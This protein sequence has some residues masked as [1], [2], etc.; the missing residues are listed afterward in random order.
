[1]CAICVCEWGE[2]EDGERKTQVDT[3]CPSRWLSIAVL[4]DRFFT[5]P[6]A[7]GLDLLTHPF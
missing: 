2:G 6:E 3:R 7:H 5:E 4:D 1:V